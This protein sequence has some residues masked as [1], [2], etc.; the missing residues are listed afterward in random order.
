MP[1]DSNVSNYLVIQF[2]LMMQVMQHLDDL[3]YEVKWVG[4]KTK[5][6]FKLC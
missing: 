2:N 6:M 4:N 1:D 5:S 3:L